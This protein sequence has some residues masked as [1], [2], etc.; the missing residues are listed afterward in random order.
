MFEF[1]VTY[2]GRDGAMRRENATA[3]RPPADWSRADLEEVLDKATA[4]AG[5]P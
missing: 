4:Y 5:I 2:I 3:S 1:V